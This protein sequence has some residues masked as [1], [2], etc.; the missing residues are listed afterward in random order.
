MLGRMSQSVFLRRATGTFGIRIVGL[1]LQF[2]GAIMIARLLGVA[3]FGVYAY[4][5]TWVVIVGLLLS[6]GVTQLATR[7]L[8]RFLALGQRVAFS[9]FVTLL[10][11]LII[12]VGALC[13]GVL[14]GLEHAGFID[15]AVGWPWLA[16]GIVIHGLILGCAAVLQ[17]LQQM[18]KSQAI[19]TILRQGLFLLALGVLFVW[20]AQPSAA[21][22]FRLSVVLSIP[23]LGVMIW[24][25]G[26]ALRAIAWPVEHTSAV[27]S[28]RIWLI[29]ALPLLVMLFASQMQTNLDVLL[30][31]VLAD[32]ADVGRYR[33]ASRG[34]DLMLIAT[35]IA[36]QVLGPMLAHTLAQGH[37]QEGQAMITQ[38]TLIATVLGGSICV[39]MWVGSSL[40]LGLF[41]PDFVAAT[42]ILRILVSAQMIG[43]LCGPVSVIL[44]TLGH[45]RLVLCV[46]L[47][48]LALNL[49]LNLILIPLYGPLGAAWAT[50][51]AVIA[52]QVLLMVSVMQRS[53]F[54][55][56]LRPLWRA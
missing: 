24:V 27:G 3:A 35:G 51:V 17:S 49:C 6:L 12:G 52:L 45:E 39:V 33:V 42:P 13:A 44:V 48:V 32:A 55:P 40:Y 54:D 21:E 37:D 4:A 56:T 43:I 19:E 9:R 7:E 38:S 22:V 8:P 50:F 41:G 26:R 31:G 11:G 46:S 34:A 36:I 53:V 29:C 1:A 28:R 47:G 30:I 16:L 18:V 25:T 14:F 23:V 20:G 15:V 5:F 10:C 2:A